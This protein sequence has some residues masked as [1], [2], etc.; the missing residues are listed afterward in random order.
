MA[1]SPHE[2]PFGQVVGGKVLASIGAALKRN[3]GEI[4]MSFSDDR[5]QFAWSERFVV[6]TRVLDGTFP[7]YGKVI[8]KEASKRL[9]I[10]RA[11]LLRAARQSAIAASFA[12][13]KVVVTF[14]DQKLALSA[15]G[16]NEMVSESIIREVVTYGVDGGYSFAINARYL[17]ECLAAVD[18]ATVTLE[19]NGALNPIIIR[20]GVIGENRAAD[21]DFLCVIM[22]M[23]L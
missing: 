19:M 4:K 11:A 20:E 18:F 6:E 3:K 9:V 5:A 7:T 14:A 1:K 15:G 13:Q 17:A 10:P 22:P 23:Q 2:K 8:P 21:A 12:G 16:S